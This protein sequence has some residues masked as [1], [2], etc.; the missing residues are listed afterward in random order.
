MWYENN[1]ENINNDA[2]EDTEDDEDETQKEYNVKHQSY[3][4]LYKCSLCS[5]VFKKNVIYKTILTKNLNV[6][7]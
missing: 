2:Y 6:I 4:K 7:N 5:R 1:V 3:K